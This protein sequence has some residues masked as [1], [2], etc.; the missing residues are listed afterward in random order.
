MICERINEKRGVMACNLYGT[1][2]RGGGP[3]GGGGCFALRAR[4]RLFFMRASSGDIPRPG[5]G[6]F[7]LGGKVTKTPPAPFGPDSPLLS[8]TLPGEELPCPVN[9]PIFFC[10]ILLEEL[11]LTAF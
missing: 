8:N 5:A 6:D 7:A 4:G 10:Q 2:K 3:V 9:A 11:R 1:D